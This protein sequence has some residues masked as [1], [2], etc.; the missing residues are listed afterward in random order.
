MDGTTICACPICNKDLAF[1]PICGDDRAT[2]PN[3]CLMERKS[4]L[5][6]KVIKATKSEPC[7]KF[8]FQQDFVLIYQHFPEFE[9]VRQSLCLNFVSEFFD[10]KYNRR[11]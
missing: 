6:K 11:Q 7:G 2:Y 5:T 8:K 9:N 3:R 1:D 10:R 4:C